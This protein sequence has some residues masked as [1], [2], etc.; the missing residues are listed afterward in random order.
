MHLIS[1]QNFPQATRVCDMM[2]NTVIY[3]NCVVLLFFLLKDLIVT[4]LA[5]H[6]VHDTVVKVAGVNYLKL[7]CTLARGKCAHKPA[8]S[9][10]RYTLTCRPS[11][12]W[13]QQKWKHITYR[14]TRYSKYVGGIS[15]YCC[16]AKQSGHLATV[17]DYFPF[18]KLKNYFK[19]LYYKLNLFISF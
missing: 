15:I 12:V 10:T 16:K 8:A 14:F 9:T 1:Y 4:K 5:L 18:I 2:T 6:G 17:S 19:L 7:P 3:H 13:S 11:R